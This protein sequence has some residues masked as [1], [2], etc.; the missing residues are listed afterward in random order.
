MKAT[1]R[2]LRFLQIIFSDGNASA[3]KAN[4]QLSS[5]PLQAHSLYPLQPRCPAPSALS[6]NLVFRRLLSGT[7]GYLISTELEAVPD[8]N[9]ELN[10]PLLELCS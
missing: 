2:L 4:A 7:S 3:K 10:V 5:A 1:L 8:P 6:I 9:G